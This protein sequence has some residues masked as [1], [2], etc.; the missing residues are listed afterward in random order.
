MSGPT[1]LTRRFRLPRCQAGLARAA[2]R[3]HLICGACSYQA[4]VTA[5]TIF[6]GSRQP[7]TL[8]FRAIWRVTAQKDGASALGLRRIPG[9]GTYS[10]A[11]AGST[12][13]GV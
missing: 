4:S 10:S 2:T 1:A 3:R 11:W 8:W 12:S 5:G 7:L 13:C 9:L 6:H